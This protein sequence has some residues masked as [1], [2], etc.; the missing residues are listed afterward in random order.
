MDIE[1]VSTRGKPR[2]RVKGWPRD[3]AVPTALQI[4][5]GRSRANCTED[6]VR[7]HYRRML[8]GYKSAAPAIAPLGCKNERAVRF[9]WHSTRCEV[10]AYLFNAAAADGATTFDANGS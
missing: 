5:R 8:P 9:E 10:S 6:G 7:A 2:L 3:H 1:G 4:A